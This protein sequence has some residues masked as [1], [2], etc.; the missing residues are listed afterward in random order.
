MSDDADPHLSRGKRLAVTSLLVA[1]FA[2][3]VP[4]LI[5]D[6]QHWPFLLYPMYS[7][8][9]GSTVTCLTAVGVSPDQKE[10]VLLADDLY[11]FNQMFVTRALGRVLRQPDGP[12]RVQPL[13]REILD[14][15]ERT[16]TEIPDLTDLKINGVRLYEAVYP[17]D[18]KKLDSE[19]P[20][21]RRL[22]AEVA[23]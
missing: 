19:H 21:S 8:R 9:L 18:E 2:A 3:H 13:L 12:T 5:T 15:H 7:H 22:I 6:Q 4:G 14:R 10:T 17:L 20:I 1:L 23:K 16:R 11:P